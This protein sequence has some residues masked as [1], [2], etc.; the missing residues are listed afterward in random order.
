MK[1]SEYAT[2]RLCGMTPAVSMNYHTLITG[3]HTMYDVLDWLEVRMFRQ[4]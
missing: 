4:A 3:L 1:L 2:R